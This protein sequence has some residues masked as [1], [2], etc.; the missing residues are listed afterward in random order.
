MNKFIRRDGDRQ[1]ND[2]VVNHATSAVA[3]EVVPHNTP[4]VGNLMQDVIEAQKKTLWLEI[5]HARNHADWN[6]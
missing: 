5:P 1:V 4:D 6:E 3:C 2:R